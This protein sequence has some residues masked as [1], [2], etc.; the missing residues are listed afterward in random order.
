MLPEKAL[1]PSSCIVELG[2]VKCPPGSLGVGPVIVK[3]CPK[4]GSMIPL[5]VTADV[6]VHVS[7]EEE[8]CAKQPAVLNSES[9]KATVLTHG[10][11]G[12]GGGGGF[13]EGATTSTALVTVAVWEGLPVPPPPVSVS[14]TRTVC[15][16]AVV[17]V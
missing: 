11:G 9:L 7:G 8:V 5:S 4:S 17:N 1:K 3:V 12:G 14:L 16:P 2:A 6:V 13:D 10:F 15:G